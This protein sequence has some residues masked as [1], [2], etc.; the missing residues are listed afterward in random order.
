MLA[1]LAVMSI[2]FYLTLF[3][4]SYALKYLTAS[5]SGVLVYLTVP[6]GYVLDHL[7]FGKEVEK[8][9]VTGACIIVITSVVV[10][11]IKS[12]GCAR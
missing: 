4:M 8:V 9:E 11:L 3:L 7:V 1:F 6:C 10:A 2:Q 5:L 12:L